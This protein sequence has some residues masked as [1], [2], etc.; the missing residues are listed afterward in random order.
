VGP[1]VFARVLRLTYS[2]QSLYNGAAWAMRL[3]LGTP[4]VE[5]GMYI[6]TGSSDLVVTYVCVCVPSCPA[7]LQQTPDIRTR[8]CRKTGC[9]GCSPVGRTYSPS[10]S[11]SSRFVNCDGGNPSEFESFVDWFACRQRPWP[12][13]PLAKQVTSPSSVPPVSTRHARTPLRMSLVKSC[14]SPPFKVCSTQLRLAECLELPP[15]VP[16]S[17]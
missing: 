17:T 1:C 7:V 4:P 3:R 15:W 14:R 13:A 9:T 2:L 5:Y 6:D 11:S 12:D 16:F 8:R 10:M